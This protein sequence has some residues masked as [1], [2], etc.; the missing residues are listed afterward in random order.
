MLRWYFQCLLTDNIGVILYSMFVVSVLI[1]IVRVRP[2]Y[3]E[4]SEDQMVFESLGWNSETALVTTPATITGLETNNFTRRQTY[5]APAHWAWNCRKVVVQPEAAVHWQIPEER[6]MTSA[7]DPSPSAANSMATSWVWRAQ[8][9]ATWRTTQC[10]LTRVRGFRP[11]TRITTATRTTIA[12]ICSGPV[13]GSELRVTWTY[14]RQSA[15]PRIST[16][17][18]RTSSGLSRIRC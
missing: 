16:S 13:G 10:P 6:G 2:S 15:E 14:L 11:S 4:I 12:P 5:P 1:K 7:T 17:I 18:R 9:P 3:R 8:S